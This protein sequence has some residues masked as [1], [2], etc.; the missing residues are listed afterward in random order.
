[1]HHEHINNRQSILNLLCNIFFLVA[2]IAFLLFYRN[3]N[4]AP[5]NSTLNETTVINI[6]KRYI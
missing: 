6:P 1:M 3:R 2:N 4:N 5:K